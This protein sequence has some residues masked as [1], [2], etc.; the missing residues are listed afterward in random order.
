MASPLKTRHTAVFACVNLEIT[1]RFLEKTYWL[2][3][4]LGYG[5]DGI[6]N[7]YKKQ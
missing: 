2:S 6:E 1:V 5:V 3:E 4:M 7:F